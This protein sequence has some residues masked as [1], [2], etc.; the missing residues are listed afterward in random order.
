M[1]FGV[2]KV[3]LAEKNRRI[4]DLEKQIESLQYAVDAYKKRLEGEMANASFAIDW[5][6]MNVFSIE[7]LWENGLPKTVLGYILS[8]PVIYTE[9]DDQRVTHKDIVR[10]WTLYCSAEKHEELVKEF[11]EWVSTK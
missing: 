4:D 3:T 10:E 6:T 2:D 7:R 11:K 9:G 1:M 5:D 8:E